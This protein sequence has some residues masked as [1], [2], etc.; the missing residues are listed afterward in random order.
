MFEQSYLVCELKHLGVWHLLHELA[1][2]LNIVILIE[3]FIIIIHHVVVIF[4]D[5]IIFIWK[6]LIL[7]IIDELILI[8]LKLF[9]SL[10]QVCIVCW[11][12]HIQDWVSLFRFNFNF[13][14]LKSV[15]DCLNVVSLS[16]KFFFYLKQ[17]SAKFQ[18]LFFASVLLLSWLLI[19]K[20]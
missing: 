19:V 8:D 9:D 7:L 11:G 17:L 12:F 10:I 18:E 13:V 6:I 1:S 4:V 2:I 20:S 15:S 14:V 3:F 16:C 5:V